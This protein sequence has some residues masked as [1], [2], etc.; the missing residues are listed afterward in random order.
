[1]SA[2]TLP[3]RIEA[4]LMNRISTLSPNIKSQILASESPLESSTEKIKEIG[5]SKSS[6]STTPATRDELFSILLNPSSS[7]RAESERKIPSSIN[8]KTSDLRSQLKRGR[9]F[10]EPTSFIIP[11]QYF[12]DFPPNIEGSD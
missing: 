12:G 5:T 9:E 8:I 6:K 2:L 1:M 10:E 11:K 3:R 4:L 7:S